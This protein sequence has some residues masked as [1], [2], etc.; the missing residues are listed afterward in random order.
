MVGDLMKYELLLRYG[1]LY[2]DANFE[3]LR[4]RAFGAILDSKETVV[5]YEN[6][7]QLS[8]GAL[9]AP[10]GSDFAKCC[11]GAVKDLRDFRP[12]NEA[13]GPAIVSACVQLKARRLPF[14]LMYPYTP[15]TG[16]GGADA[17]LRKTRAAGFVPIEGNWALPTEE[18]AQRYSSSWAVDHFDNGGKSWLTAAASGS[19]VAVLV[20]SDGAARGA[21]QTIR[22]T[23][24]SGHSNVYFVVGMCCPVAPALRV[25]HTCKSATYFPKLDRRCAAVDAGLANEQSTYNDLIWSDSP[26]VYHNLPQKLLAGYTWAAKQSS[27]DWIVKVDMDTFVRVAA[28]EEYLTG[29]KYNSSAMAMIAAGIVRGTKTMGLGGRNGEQ[30]RIRQLY[31]QY[32]PWPN[33]AGHAVSRAVATYAM[34]HA[35][36]LPIAT[37]EDVSLGIWLSLAS[38]PV[39]YHASKRFIGH[40]GNCTDTT[41][42]VIGH[43]I[44]PSKM[45]ECF[46]YADEGLL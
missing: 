15:W 8:A 4:P 1:G 19:K 12:A 14:N 25:P 22:E 46:E 36:S 32:P 21:R 34:T 23:W 3:I 37:G 30:L 43:G 28:L 13:T 20:L 5:A 10:A 27:A 18:C 24:A 41:A 16:R 39:F 42:V 29:G 26:D 2:L 7:R 38:P 35:A 17:C 33:G 11:V 9:Y 6:E 31:K 45:R 44:T 40:N